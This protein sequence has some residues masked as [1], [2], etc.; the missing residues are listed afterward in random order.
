MFDQNVYSKVL[1]NFNV[2]KEK[3]RKSFKIMI[4]FLFMGFSENVVLCGTK[5]KAA[6][7]FSPSAVGR[8]GEKQGGK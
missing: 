4:S 5:L 6:G 2:A 8:R 3:K 7:I 1:V